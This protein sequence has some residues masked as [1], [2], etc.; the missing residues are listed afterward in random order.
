MKKIYTQCFSVEEA[1]AIGHFIMSRGYEGV[2]NDS[3]RY[4]LMCIKSAIKEN[5][6]HNRNY[7][8][9]GVNGSRL[10]VAKNRKMMRHQGS[11]KF[12][13]KPRVFREKLSRY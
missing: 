9:I 3:Y 8:Y 12:I 5:L 6:I 7:C 4:C 10:V 13:E 2:Q 1:D 11:Y